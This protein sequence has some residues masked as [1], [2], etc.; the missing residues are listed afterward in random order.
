MVT[1]DEFGRLR[2]KDLVGGLRP[3]AVPHG[4][5]EW[6]GHVWTAES[7]GAFTTFCWFDDQV[8]RAIEVC[9]DELSPIE[10]ECIGLAIGLNLKH[11]M[12]ADV[13]HQ[14]IGDPIEKVQFTSDRITFR[15]RVA[16][17]EEYEVWMHIHE[18]RRLGLLHGECAVATGERLKE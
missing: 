3:V 10:A 1:H 13:V 2:L 5:W 15:Y 9:V 17:P 14:L 7:T 11:G 4:G 18:H 8:T 12:T 16:E 6:L